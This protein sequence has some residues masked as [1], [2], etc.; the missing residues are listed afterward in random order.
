MNQTNGSQNTLRPNFSNNVYFKGPNGWY[1]E[2]KN[3][4]ISK[5]MWVPKNEPKQGDL[6]H[7][8]IIK[9]NIVQTQ[10]MSFASKS[11]PRNKIMDVKSPLEKRFV[12]GE[13][14]E[15][16]PTRVFCNYCC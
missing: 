1:Y 14:L 11:V 5:Q 12:K 2:N 13:T 15:E 3:Q 6:Q 16:K 10:S 4:T 7:K 9:Q 8:K